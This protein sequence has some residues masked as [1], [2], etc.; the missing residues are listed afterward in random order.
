VSHTSV[1][2]QRSPPAMVLLH[3]STGSMSSSMV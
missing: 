3:P 1:A 2:L